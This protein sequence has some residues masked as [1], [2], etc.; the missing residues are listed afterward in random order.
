MTMTWHVRHRLLALSLLGLAFVLGTGTVGYLSLQQMAGMAARQ[1]L[2]SEALRSQM[3]ADMMHDTLRS[4]VLAALL[5]ASKQQDNELAAAAKDIREHTEE[6]ISDMAKLKGMAVNDE[7]TASV[8]KTQTQ[9]N[10]YIKSAN[11]LVTLA[12]KDLPSA[13]RRL[14][15]F[16]S[17]FK[18]LEA[19]M[20]H[21]SDLIED[22]ERQTREQ[23]VATASTAGN[24][25]MATALTAT[26]LLLA[27]NA[28]IGRGIAGPLATA[29]Q[30]THQVAGGDLTL[31][32][33]SDGTD[34]TA[35]LLAALQ[36]MSGELGAIVGEVRA[37][38]ESVAQGSTEIAAGSL[39]LSQRTEEQAS[40]LEQTAAAL[41]QMTAA[42]NNNAETARR[43]SEL[44]RQA[45]QAATAGGEA[46]GRVVSTMAEISG[47]SRRIADI[48]GVID[49]IAFQTNI[50]ALN[51]AVEAARAGEQGRGFA[52]VAGEVRLLA[53]RSADA[54]REIKALIADSVTK[55]EQGTTEVDQAGHT[56]QGVVRQV[57]GVSQLISEIDASSHEQSR[58]IGQVGAAMTSL[59]QMTQQ[60]AAL[61]E[62]T[63]AAAES[64]KVQANRLTGLVSRF[65][66]RT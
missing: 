64:L 31:Q 39:N 62:Q 29:L 48:I 18:A 59:D 23:G 38:A 30:A 3:E 16:V 37:S 47:S 2:A 14:P 45:A 10:A 13:E 58:G 26:L 63:A 7:I 50:L 1:S 21:V 43:A 28:W 56:V 17:A 19:D 36:S 32:L 53:H 9:L 11:E 5:A 22:H 33:R 55:V 25:M 40:S 27:I 61:V 4:D 66:L 52:V 44:A 60:N 51:A 24:T 65:K 6:F 54:A 46:V 20:A 49:G 57:D 15:Q 8:Q 34:E 42:V 35:Q 41:E 12:G